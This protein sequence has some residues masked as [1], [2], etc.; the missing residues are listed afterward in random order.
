MQCNKCGNEGIVFQP[1]SGQHLCKRH[2]I[3][4]VEA[5]AKRSIRVHHWLRPGDHIGVAL[6]GDC[7]S[8]ALLYFLKE[9]TSNRRD[10]RISTLAIGD[11][12][13]DCGNLT[14]VRKFSESLGIPCISGS[15]SEKSGINGADIPR[16]SGDI[17][18]VHRGELR[19]CHLTRIA[20]ENGITRFA[21]GYTLDNAAKAV[22]IQFLNGRFHP[23]DNAGN[24]TKKNS[25]WIYPFIAV[26]QDEIALYAD[27][28]SMGT[29]L[30]PC[31]PGDRFALETEVSSVLEEY[32]DLHPGTKYALLNLGDQLHACGIGQPFFLR[33]PHQAALDDCEKCE[34]DW[35]VTEHAA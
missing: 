19:M 3:G 27:L 12:A 10:I 33:C 26:P 32:T 22:L 30:I 15:L 2:F 25:F 11:C 35:K 18:S 28:H 17:I 1:Y 21:L 31:L 6:A 23:C 20:M 4:D 7:Q 13:S 16:E 34:F 24:E 9:L 29:N 5:K 14:E 8:M